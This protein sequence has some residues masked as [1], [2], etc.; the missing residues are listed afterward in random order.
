MFG[1]KSIHESGGVLRYIAPEDIR[2]FGSVWKFCNLDYAF[3]PKTGQ[4]DNP[5]TTKYLAPE[6]NSGTLTDFKPTS[7]VWSMG[8]ILYEI[9]ANKHQDSIL[10]DNNL[11]FPDIGAE[12]GNFVFVLRN[13]LRLDP[14][15][16]FATA[17]LFLQAFD[18]A[19]ERPRPKDE[20]KLLT[21]LIRKVG[22][23]TPKQY[24][25]D[26]KLIVYCGDETA[27]LMFGEI[28]TVRR[29]KN[30]IVVHTDRSITR[31]HAD[32]TWV[33]KHCRWFSRT[34]VAFC[35]NGD[36]VFILCDKKNY[37]REKKNVDHRLAGKIT[38]IEIDKAYLVGDSERGQEAF[39]VKERK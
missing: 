25:N 20:I 28:A 14:E 34:P 2:K 22:A 7:D 23:Q 38:K 32:N 30:E 10:E 17:D 21:R 5:P 36:E 37:I 24:A 12:C 4:V 1:L 6:H 9:L 15:G 3:E 19:I 29:V 18:D 33:D 31:L 39:K 11:K 13:A 26:L 8:R 35:R 16:R 27:E